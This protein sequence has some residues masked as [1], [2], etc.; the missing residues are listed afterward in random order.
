MKK[1]WLVWLIAIV[2]AAIAVWYYLLRPGNIIVSP[3]DALPENSILVVELKSLESFS[4]DFSSVP[5]W[6]DLKQ[7]QL[8]RKLDENVLLLQE[9]SSKNSEIYSATHGGKISA[10]AVSVKSGEVE[11]VFAM[12]ARGLKLNELELQYNNEKAQASK[13]TSSKNDIY[14]FTASGFDIACSKVGNVFL[15]SKSKI[16]VE[17]S[18]SQ[19][20]NSSGL[21]SSESFQSIYALNAKNDISDFYLNLNQL[22]QYA[23]FF[24]QPDLL[25]NIDMLRRFTTW[26]GFE[27]TFTKNEILINGY[28][29]GNKSEPS[30]YLSRHNGTETSF[31]L[32]N[33]FLL[34]NTAYYIQSG[35]T[36]IVDSLKESGNQIKAWNSWLSP[37]YTYVVSQS[38]D[39]AV[40]NK[41]YLIAEITENETAL[42]QLNS[43]SE[44]ENTSYRQYTIYAISNNNLIYY[45]TGFGHGQE[46]IYVA[47]VQGYLIAA[48]SINQLM[49]VIDGYE[50]QQTL[51][52]DVA[53][54]ELQS[55]VTSSSNFNVFVNLTNSTSILQ[56]ILRDDTISKIFSL[57]KFSSMLF[58]F[59]AIKN[60]HILN[61]AVLYSREAQ[62]QSGFAWKTQIDNPVAEGPFRV[63]NH[64]DGHDNILLQ[65]SANQIY[66]LSAN[67]NAIWKRQLD[68]RIIGTVYSVDFYKNKKKQ[69]L[70]AASNGIYLIDMLG[71]DVEG[72]PITLT[73]EVTSPLSVFDYD[74]TGDYR[75]F[76]GCENGNVYG[77]YKDGK[78]LPGWSPLKNAGIMENEFTY[79]QSDQKDYIAMSNSHGLLSVKNRKGE[80]RIKNIKSDTRLVTALMPD[81]RKNIS[82]FIGIDERYR[83]VKLMLDGTVSNEII[84]EDIS[85]ALLTEIDNEDETELFYLTSNTLVAQK[86][87]GQKIFET[88]VGNTTGYKL[89]LFTL[90]NKTYYGAYNSLTQKIILMNGDG[91]MFKGFPTEGA[92]RF[93]VIE[94]GKL[95][96]SSVGNFVIAY[97]IN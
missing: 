62:A 79:V 47:V 50:N 13:Y 66:L 57:Q 16:L 43:F 3:I 96:I 65:D 15:F 10:A 75:M 69:I 44:S 36:S 60:M 73:A 88:T 2:V 24:L 26:V 72:F 94:S 8:V 92:S 49:N 45:L 85:D 40:T 6:Q 23:T 14:E 30:E 93:I 21:G 55:L 74:G 27:C 17:A 20:K 35:G 54:L 84:A 29:A 86:L 71:R 28:A 78:P 91:I 82:A 7:L 81:N 31:E 22:A 12:H 76:I 89:D 59:T 19:L 48:Y 37:K 53:H 80:D 90:G 1:R 95:L 63:E 46:T 41:S 51:H 18:V 87:N 34:K 77:F 83:L 9:L 5:Q 4:S 33:N 70:F 97:S 25:K 67:G 61:G 32:V 64:I 42:Q 68:A 39:A 58:S 38:F 56:N 52:Q 11:F